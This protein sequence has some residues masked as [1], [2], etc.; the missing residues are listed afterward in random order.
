M[1]ST[2]KKRSMSRENSI[3]KFQTDHRFAIIVSDAL[4][5]FYTSKN[6]FDDVKQL[7]GE[8]I[9]AQSYSK[10]IIVMI[11][12]EH[13]IDLSFEEEFLQKNRDIIWLI[14]TKMEAKQLFSEKN[15][16]FATA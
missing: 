10:M 14:E 12:E 2:P 7:Y 5:D 6:T 15:M 4:S 11:N 16:L 9:L 3:L 13:F 8:I 1:H